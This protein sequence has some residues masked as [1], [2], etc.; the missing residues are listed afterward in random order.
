MVLIV[1]NSNISV[2]IKAFL[3]VNS[4]MFYPSI[5]SKKNLYA[6][7]GLDSLTIVLYKVLFVQNVEKIFFG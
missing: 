5:W 3:L 1:V 6:S 7:V 4:R 2:Q